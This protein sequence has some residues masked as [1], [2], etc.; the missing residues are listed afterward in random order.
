MA[1]E[2]FDSRHS[3]T[4][5]EDGRKVRTIVNS[6]R[7]TSTTEAVRI[8]ILPPLATFVNSPEVASKIFEARS[9][10]TQQTSTQLAM[11]GNASETSGLVSNKMQTTL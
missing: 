2:K 10:P 6:S 7:L 9:M 11:F 5:G 8:M 3:V 1:Q 4:N